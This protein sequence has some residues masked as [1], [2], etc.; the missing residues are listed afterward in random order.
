MQADREGNKAMA[1]VRIITFERDKPT[2]TRA[3]LDIREFDGPTAATPRTWS[4]LAREQDRRALIMDLMRQ[5]DQLADGEID[6]ISIVL[7]S[8]D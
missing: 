1:A 2:D 3:V 6:E 4:E 7:G 5:I 8:S